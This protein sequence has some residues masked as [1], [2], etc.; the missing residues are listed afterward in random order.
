M[1]D[2]KYFQCSW[3]HTFDN[4]NY[5]CIIEPNGFDTNTDLS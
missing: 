5:A 2:G 4:V 1:N 3:A